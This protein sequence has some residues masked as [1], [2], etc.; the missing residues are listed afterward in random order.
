[1][2]EENQDLEM[3]AT[4]TAEHSDSPANGQLNNRLNRLEENNAMLQLMADPDIARVL[5]LKKAGKPVN[6]AEVEDIAPEPEVD[7]IAQASEGLEADDPARKLLERVGKMLES[8]TKAKDKQIADLTER[9]QGVESIAG[10]VTRKGV[11]DQIEAAKAKYKDLAQYKDAMMS[12][13]PK[14]PNASVEQVYILAKLASGKLKLQEG[15]THSERPTSQP[16]RTTARKP[17]VQPMKPGRAAFKTGL[18]D[19]LKDLTLE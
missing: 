14:F 6:I 13:A 8:T 2:D 9:L 4:E 12:L 11:V 5:A 15:S 19:I 18:A 17:G 3:D 1:M 16:P 10:D 7:P